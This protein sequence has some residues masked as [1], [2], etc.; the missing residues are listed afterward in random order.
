MSDKEETKIS[1][2]F[3]KAASEEHKEACYNTMNVLYDHMVNSKLA[4]VDC[5]YA[6]NNEETETI[7]A[8]LVDA[9]GGSAILPLVKLLKANDD[10]SNSLVPCIKLESE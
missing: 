8:A 5:V 10:V 4:V 3:S 2:A 6:D 1:Y 7:I 9:E